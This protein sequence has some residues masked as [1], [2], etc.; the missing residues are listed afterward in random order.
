MSLFR[1]YAILEAMLNWTGSRWI[2]C[3][4][5]ASA[6]YFPAALSLKYSYVEPRQPEGVVLRLTRPFEQIQGNDVSAVADAPSLDSLADTPEF[7]ERSPFI[8]YENETPLGP[9]HRE[10]DEI[11]KYGHGRFSHWHGSG[12]VFSSSDGTNPSSNGRTY[13]VVQPR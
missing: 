4:F 7:P 8:L 10:H 12:F 11:A 2:V 13:W 9:A 1:G 3:A 5:I 6:I